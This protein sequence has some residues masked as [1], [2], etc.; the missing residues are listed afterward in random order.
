MSFNFGNLKHLYLRNMQFQWEAM[1][2]FS[3]SSI[4]ESLARVVNG[5]N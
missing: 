5:C 1:T 2:R 4:E 3:M